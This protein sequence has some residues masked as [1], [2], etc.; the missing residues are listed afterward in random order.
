MGY[1]YERFLR[2]LVS[3]KIDPDQAL[4]RYG[5]P[6]SGD[7]WFAAVKTDL[8]DNG[9]FPISSYLESKDT[10]LPLR[11]G[12]L[13]WAQR[14]GFREL[15]EMQ[16]EFGEADNPDLSVAF[17][18]FVNPSSR[19][20]AAMFVD[21]RATEAEV[22]ESLQEY[23]NS[24]VT[25]ASLEIFKRLFWDTS[26]TTSGEWD[27]L[28]PSLLT[29]KERHLISLA[30]EGQNI[31]LARGSVDLSIDVRVDVM[32]KEML[33]TNYMMW[34]NARSV[35]SKDEMK[36]WGESNLR[37]MKE[38]REYHRYNTSNEGVPKAGDFEGLFSV[39]TSKSV[40]PTLA[41]LQGE[42]APL[43]NQNQ[44]EEADA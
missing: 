27:D 32:L 29:K 14:E 23:L 35:K 13:D 17:Q 28:I 19:P 15:W 9:P 3:R 26:Q 22:C 24:E 12:V 1:P 33:N 41:E 7:L 37:V 42:V 5:L 30:R 40:H 21:S 18:L 38:L 16:P 8:I 31:N 11:D 2:F 36:E 20:V 10:V 25:S 44:T 6:S 4:N 34:L 39:K 43:P